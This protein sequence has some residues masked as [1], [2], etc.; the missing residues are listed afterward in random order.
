MEND[1]PEIKA[2]LRQENAVLTPVAVQLDGGRITALVV[3]AEIDGKDNFS[4]LAEPEFQPGSF[5]PTEMVAASAVANWGFLL[6]R[7]SD[8]LPKL[9]FNFIK[10]DLGNLEK[11][12]KA[13]QNKK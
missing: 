6:L 5:E 1:K 10:D 7:Q 8:D 2:A 13:R 4:L 3:K 12:I 9:R 11:W